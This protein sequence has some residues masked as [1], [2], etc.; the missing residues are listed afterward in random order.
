MIFSPAITTCIAKIIKPQ[1]SAKT[2]AV[3]SAKDLINALGFS[4]S[5]RA[6]DAAMNSYSQRRWPSFDDY[7]ST[8]S[9]NSFLVNP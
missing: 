5:I 9:I 1:A 7:D 6:P 4:G 2:A 8:E 3:A